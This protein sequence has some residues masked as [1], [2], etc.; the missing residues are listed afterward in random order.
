M[1]ALLESLIEARKARGWTQGQLAQRAMLSG[2]TVQQVESGTVDPYFSTLYEMTRALG[3]Q[4]MA[5]PAPL[6]DELESF[7]QAGGRW[8][9]QPPGVN[10]PLSIVDEILS[11]Q[12]NLKR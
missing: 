11:G 2:T 5:V 8:L 4:L 6:R 3:M 7:V 1:H 9:G 10:A 12:L